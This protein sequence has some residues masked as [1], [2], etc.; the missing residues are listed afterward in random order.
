MVDER[1]RSDFELHVLPVRNLDIKRAERLKVV[2]LPILL[3]A[4]F[5]E[6][7][8]VEKFAGVS[9]PNFV[10]QS[11]ND[12]ECFDCERVIARPTVEGREVALGCEN[13]GIPDEGVV[14]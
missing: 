9:G 8:S 10:Q 3:V 1:V 6:A 12:S 5:D 2:A 4:G 7:V 13:T 11:L 14:T